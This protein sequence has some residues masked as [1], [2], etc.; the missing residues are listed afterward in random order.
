MHYDRCFK[1]LL[2]CLPTIVDCAFKL[3]AKINPPFQNILLGYFNATERRATNT[4]GKLSAPLTERRHYE[5]PQEDEEHQM[6]L[7]PEIAVV[8]L[9]LLKR[10]WIS[11][12][13]K[14]GGG[15]GKLPG[16]RFKIQSSHAT[17]YS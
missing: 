3:R 17:G 11:Q 9:E 6:S 10:V 14:L 7:S 8:E 12:N 16:F 1:I 13:F 15:C 5:V 4:T 2:P